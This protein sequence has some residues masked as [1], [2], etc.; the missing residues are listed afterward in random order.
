MSLYKKILLAITSSLLF[1]SPA[2]AKEGPH[3]QFAD[4]AIRQGATELREEFDLIYI[5]SGGGMSDNIE[6]IHAYFLSY[7]KPSIELARKM[8]VKAIQKL[9]TRINAHEKI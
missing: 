1:L 6:E 8:A 7:Q 3:V 4:E 2:I 9:Q 5:G